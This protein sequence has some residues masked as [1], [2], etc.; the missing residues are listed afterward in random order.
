MK[1]EAGVGR[2]RATAPLCV[3]LLPAEK[4]MKEGKTYTCTFRKGR[5]GLHIQHDQLGIKKKYLGVLLA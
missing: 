4:K 3:P 5:T 1:D 2:N